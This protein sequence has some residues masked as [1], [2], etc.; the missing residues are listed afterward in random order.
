MG[1]DVTATEALLRAQKLQR[2]KRKMLMLGR[3]AIHVSKSIL[4][5][6]GQR[7]GL[8][9]TNSVFSLNEYVEQIQKNEYYSEVLFKEIG[10]E[11]IESLDF[12]D[13]EKPTYIHNLNLPLRQDIINKFDFIF[14]GGTT[15]HVFNPSQCYQNIIDLLEIEG[16]FLSVTCNN[17]FSGH[18]FYQFSPE[19]FISC[20]IQKYG[21]ELLELYVCKNGALY[22]EWVPVNY[23]EDIPGKRNLT[24]ISG[25]DE[26]YIIA[27][28]KKIGIGESL[29]TNPPTQLSYVFDKKAKV[30][31]EIDLTVT[32]AFFDLGRE[33][34]TGYKRSVEDYLNY[35]KNMLSLDCNMVIYTQENFYQHF[36]E[37]RMKI[38]P[39]LSKTRI[40]I[41][42]LEQIPYYEYLEKI[43]NLMNDDFFIHNIKNRHPDQLRPEANYPIYNI[44]QFAKSKFVSKTI[45]SN[46]FNTDYHCWMDAGIYHSGFPEEFRG[47]KFPSKNQDTLKDGKIH[48]FYRVF[49]KEKDIHKVSY[50][51][52][53]DDVRIVGAWFGGHKNALETY[54]NIINKVVDDSIKEKVISDDQNIYTISYLENKDLFTL[55]D[56]NFAR[57]PYFA[58]LDYFI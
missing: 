13:Y 29:V 58:A 17:N 2:N 10:F 18:G 15:E 30:E 41:L 55:H 39:E 47:K 46:P 54:S 42:P 35:S 52:E 43:T 6:L 8:F 25:D 4:D 33:T 44:V 50:Y 40:V 19:F 51:S 9:F 53:L 21:M 7:N 37:T 48:Q 1:L 23:L 3:Q 32:T 5:Y 28:A 31:E 26:T 45:Q 24:K 27:V 12:C 14:D 57:N 38:D 49:P 20:F 36:K 34:W 22:E 56:G 16:I 11:S